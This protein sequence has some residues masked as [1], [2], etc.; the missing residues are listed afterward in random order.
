MTTTTERTIASAR[1]YLANGN[2]GAYARLLSGAIRAADRPSTAYVI[3]AAI[4]EDKAEGLFL[5]LDT[6]TPIAKP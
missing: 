4:R 6:T 5:R 1:R 3:R 2:G